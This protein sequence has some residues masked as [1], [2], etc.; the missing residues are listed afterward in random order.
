ME[1]RINELS[2]HAGVPLPF[3]FVR[4][5]T[6]NDMTQAENSLKTAFK[7]N[8][9]NPNPRKEFFEIEPEQ[10]MA[11]L[12]LIGIEDVTPRQDELGDVDLL[13]QTDSDEFKRRRPPMR[14]D[15]F[16]IPVGAELKLIRNGEIAMVADS[17]TT[18][19]YG[20]EE[21]P[22]SAL[23]P[24]LL[25][26]SSSYVSPLDYWEYEGRLLREISNEVHGIH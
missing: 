6:V 9:V 7:K 24:I 8:R 15:A 11:I 13:E 4:A 17:G 3:D 14:F 2:R 23:T 16:D 1:R 18:V 22:I 25:G 19:N 21:F 26:W 20:E 12:D 10:A 5:V